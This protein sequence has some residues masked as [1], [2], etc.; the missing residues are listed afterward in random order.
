MK[1]S[2]TRESSK[3]QPLLINVAES[4]GSALGAI[5]AKA[6]SAQRAITRSDLAGTVK[7]EAEK[8]LRKGK[9]AASHAKSS[10]RRAKPAR[11]AGRTV[12]KAAGRVTGRRARAKKQTRE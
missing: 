12:R 7:A 11:A 4:I 9:R 5:A 1:T 6:D 2:R 8:L 3:D 10:V